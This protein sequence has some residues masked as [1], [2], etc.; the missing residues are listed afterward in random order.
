LVLVIPAA[1]IFDEYTYQFTYG[2]T[3]ILS[4]YVFSSPN[5]WKPGIK[6]AASLLIIY[7]F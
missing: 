2:R 5:R 3:R 4:F 1:F 7:E 6:I